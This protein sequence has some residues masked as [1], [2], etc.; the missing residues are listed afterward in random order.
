MKSYVSVS[1]D[2]SDEGEC[3]APGNMR[4]GGVR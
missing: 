3:V 2:K 4:I 1:C